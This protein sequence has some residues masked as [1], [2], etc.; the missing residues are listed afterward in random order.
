MWSNSFACSSFTPHSHP[1][2]IHPPTHTHWHTLTVT[3][4]TLPEQVNVKCLCVWNVLYMHVCKLI[5]N[6]KCLTA[7]TRPT[8]FTMPTHQGHLS[9]S[10]TAISQQFHL[11]Q[12]HW[13]NNPNTSMTPYSWERVKKKHE[14]CAKSVSFY[15][16]HICP[17]SIPFIHSF[18]Y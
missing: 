2:L 8:I 5:A 15:S 6:F 13:Y 18:L 16:H 10:V 11:S 12:G 7:N 14:A 1:V 9:P 4:L 3:V 17:L